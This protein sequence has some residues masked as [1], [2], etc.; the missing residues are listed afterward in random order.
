MSVPDT[1]DR[2][3]RVA[4]DRVLQRAAELQLGEAEV[5]EGLSERE[6]L[7][8]GRQVGIPARYIH[9]AMLEERSRVS[10]SRPATLLDGWVGPAEVG[11]QRVIQGSRDGVEAALLQWME[12]NEL[13]TIQRQQS[14]RITWER[15]GGMQAALKRGASV[16]SAGTARFML[17]KADEVSA[18]ITTLETGYCHVALTATLRQERGGLIGGAAAVA[19]IGGAGTVVLGALGAMVA[20]TVLPVLGGLAGGYMVSR[21]YAPRAARVQL[22]LERVLDFVERGA[23]KPAHELP[24]RHAGVLELLGGEI[25]KALASGGAGGRPER[26]PRG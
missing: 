5:G 15:L 20:I 2:L 14:G 24:A 17:A 25:R 11:A 3:D 12:K 10:F 19:S 8:L 21:L 9:Q 18:T 16:F 23:V 13:V 6:V 7:E 22:G 1:P 4:L 26:K